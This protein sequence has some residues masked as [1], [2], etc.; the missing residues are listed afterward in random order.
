ML[1]VGN[2]VGKKL[3]SID[4]VE[5]SINF[6]K[7]QKNTLNSILKFKVFD[8]ISYRGRNN[9]RVEEPKEIYIEDMNNDKKDDIIL[10]VHD[11]ILIYYQE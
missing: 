10:F 5:H 11:K 2:F 8:A 6:L 3:V 4:G 9:V 1:A 7:I